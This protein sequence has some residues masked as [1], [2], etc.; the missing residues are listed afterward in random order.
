MAMIPQENEN[1]MSLTGFFNYANQLKNKT[2]T[3]LQNSAERNLELGKNRLREQIALAESI[4]E[5]IFNCINSYRSEKINNINELNELV[6]K[7]ENANFPLSGPMLEQAFL[8]GKTSRVV[9]LVQ[10]TKAAT[11]VLGKNIEEVADIEA[12]KEELF[13]QVLNEFY[14]TSKNIGSTGRGKGSLRVNTKVIV[15]QTSGTSSKSLI[16]L[17]KLSTL[18]RK[19]LNEIIKVY[20]KGA[21]KGEKINIETI[22]LEPPKEQG[23][24]AI[25]SFNWQEVTGNL[26][27]SEAMEL[28]QNDKEGLNAINQKIKL[29]I[30]HYFPQGEDKKAMEYI[31]D[32]I[33]KADEYAFFVGDNANEII[34]LLGEM[35]AYFYLSKII[36]YKNIDATS[37]QGGIISEAFGEKPHRDL[38]FEKVFGIQ[39]KNTKQ[40]VRDYFSAYFSDNSLNNFLDK[41][42]TEDSDF[43]NKVKDYYS[44]K[45]FNIPYHVTKGGKAMG[46]LRSNFQQ[47]KNYATKREHLLSLEETIR[48]ALAT[49][50]TSLMYLSTD[51]SKGLDVNSLFF[52]AGKAFV[53]VAQILN[54]ILKD[55]EKTEGRKQ[56]TIRSS[57]RNNIIQE[58]NNQRESGPMRYG[59]DEIRADVVLTS[60][61][62]FKI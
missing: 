25:I 8:G 6:R 13:S 9:D 57:S 35:K 18:Q 49:F 24:G 43:L 53:S 39:V 23:D 7:Y 17:N 50:A 59:I 34:G 38:I 32:K 40:N 51:I 12:A 30:L 2:S 31:I 15:N 14:K 46:G 62:A 61:F 5:Q 45:E 22:Q 10:F 29:A 42:E 21:K 3:Q 20:N 33:L 36:D 47:A 56:L 27:H 37:W 58:Y 52:V 4:E 48:A 1:L 16:D 60:S 28:Y 44:L 41:L 26:T 19:T 11:Q 55:L 54:D